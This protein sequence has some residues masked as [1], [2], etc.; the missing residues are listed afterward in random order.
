MRKMIDLGRG[1]QRGPLHNII[2]TPTSLDCAG[3]VVSPRDL[4]FRR[5]FRTLVACMFPSCCAFSHE[6]DD[7]FSTVHSTVVTGTIFGHRNGRVTFCIQDD[8]RVSR[9]PLLLL[10]FSVPTS[11]LARQMHHGLLRIALD[12]CSDPRSHSSAA[13][14]YDVPLWCMYCNGRKVG[15]AVRR[16]INPAHAAVLKLMQ[17]VSAGAGVLPK[18]EDGG[19]EL[20]YLRA[21]FERVIGSADSESFHMIN[22]AG[23]SAQELSVFLLRS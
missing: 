11:Y 18:A 7:T 17:S 1:G 8:N 12:Y 16:Q 4:R 9:P 19:G 2:H 5:T 21:R 14:L 6:Y 3:I 10:E 13:P 22:P 20:M 15:F 23:S